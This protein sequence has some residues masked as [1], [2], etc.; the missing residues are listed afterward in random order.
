MTRRRRAAL[1]LGLALLLGALAASD[2]SRREAALADQLGPRVPVIASARAVR[3][4]ATLGPGDLAVREVPAR[5]VPAEAYADVQDLVGRRTA[6]A[7]P[8]GTDVVPALLAATGASGPRLRPGE[9]A[10]DVVAVG[11][12]S[13]VRPGGR[14]DV[15]ITSEGVDGQPGRTVLALRGAEVLTARA[16]T[17]GSTGDDTGRQRVAVS[18][19]VTLRQALALAEA[20]SFAR[21]LRVL[22][23]SDDEGA[24]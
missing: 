4:G 2:V 23:R 18:L 10:A 14:V 22:P 24:P 17:A 8:S 21:E 7:V 20:Q 15:A 9:R 6:V 16:V 11:P 13:L 1:L 19:R 12:P 5:Y 3:A